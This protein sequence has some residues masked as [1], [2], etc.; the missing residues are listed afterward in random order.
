MSAYGET[1]NEP[2][3]NDGDKIVHE[4]KCRKNGGNGCRQ[5]PFT[6]EELESTFVPKK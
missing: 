6:A 4:C 1:Y 2:S 3:K 5:R